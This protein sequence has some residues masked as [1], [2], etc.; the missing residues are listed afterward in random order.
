MF[1][2]RAG[3][4]PVESPKRRALPL[5]LCAVLV[6]PAL[7]AGGCSSNPH[8]SRMH[9]AVGAEA[10]P[11][12]AA[13]A[14]RRYDMEDDGMEAQVPPPPTIRFAPDDPSEPFS[15]NYGPRPAGAPASSPAQPA[16][17]PAQP[18]GGR[19]QTRS[20]FAGSVYE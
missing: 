14:S 18:P 6:L 3:R 5:W 17:K 15:P 13:E 19:P 10:E 1:Q 7:F 9:A 11:R 4:G 8:A 20:K 2:S 16:T 12:V